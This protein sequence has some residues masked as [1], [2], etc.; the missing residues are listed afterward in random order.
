MMSSERR[1]CS[2]TARSYSPAESRIGIIW[3]FGSIVVEGIETAPARTVADRQTDRQQDVGGRS[4][5]FDGVEER[6]GR[7]LTELLGGWTTVVRRG[8]EMAAKGMP[9]KPATATSSGT[10]R[11]WRR[12]ASSR[13]SAI[14]SS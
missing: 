14:L 4:R 1:F 5:E 6:K 8:L 12:S 7:Q 3:V 10:D 2:P 11:S 9:S 13:C